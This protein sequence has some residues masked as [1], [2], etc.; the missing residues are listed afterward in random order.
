M[1]AN[2]TIHTSPTGAQKA[3][4]LERYDLVPAEPLRQL[5]EHFGRGAKK[6]ADRN[7][8]AGFDWSL[9]F[10]AL[11]RHLWQFWAGEDIDTETGSPHII[12]VMWHAAVL[13]EFAA[14]HPE[15]DNRATTQI[16][17]WLEAESEWKLRAAYAHTR[18]PRI[19]DNLG[20]AEH[21][22]QWAGR[23]GRYRWDEEQRRWMRRIDRKEFWFPTVCYGHDHGGPYTEVLAPTPTPTANT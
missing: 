21:D 18:I 13:A 9:S 8:E 7:W 23:G 12:A 1:S 16:R 15:F 17:R 22:T 20:E 2:E 14:T 4:N 11:N 19:V 10:A 3:G 6:Y 5:A